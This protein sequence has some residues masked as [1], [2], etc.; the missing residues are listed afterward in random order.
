MSRQL[1]IGV[2]GG[3]GSGKSFVCNIF[4]HLSIPVYDADSRAR[5]LMNNEASVKKA[6]VEAFGEKSY[7]ENGLNRP[8]L[9]SEVFNSSDRVKQLN[10]I[11]HPA[12]GED[13]K[14]WVKENSQASYLIK[15]AALM[16]ESG[17]YKSLD[18]VIYVHA[19]KDTR[20]SR[21]QKRDPHRSVEEIKAI[22]AKQ[23]SE[24][25]LFERSDFTIYNDESRML[26]PQI[27][28][29]HRQFCQ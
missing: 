25:E 11:V 7:N 15:E 16:F 6:I 12:V 2:T 1:H 14:N 29:L 13:Y 27:L 4:K 20:I 23:L 28:E 22:I 19:D 17:S 5:W 9:A 8:Y 10:A 26:L 21:V 24:E 3:I 18:K